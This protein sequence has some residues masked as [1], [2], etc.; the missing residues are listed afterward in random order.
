MVMPR[1]QCPRCERTVAAAPIPDAPGRGRLWRHDEPGTRRDA[2][3]A[4]V[5][6]PGSLEAVELPTPVTQLTL[7]EREDAAAPDA[8]F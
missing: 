8:L 6:C 1:A 2:D 4:L 3:G 5:S 7:D